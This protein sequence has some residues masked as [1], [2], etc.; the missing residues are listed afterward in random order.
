MTHRPVQIRRATPGDAAAFARILGHPD[1]VAGTLQL[2]HTS[3]PLWLARLNEGMAPGK[4]DLQLVAELPD[5]RGQPQVVGTAGLHPVGASL[6]RRHAMSLGISVHPDAQRQGVGHALVAALCDWADNWAQVLRIELTVW[7]DN[8]HAIR[9]Y[10]RHGFAE[11]GLHRAF[12]LRGGQ[13]VDAMAMARLH[14][15]QPQLIPAEI[16]TRAT[17]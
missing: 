6:R 9:L 17:P 4:P 14:P 2:P 13:Y 11:E 3:E 15:S 5:G 12:A 7:A 16:H 8:A 1:V 10:E